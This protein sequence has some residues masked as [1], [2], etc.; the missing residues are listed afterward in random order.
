MRAPNNVWMGLKWRNG[1]AITVEVL[2][3]PDALFVLISFEDWLACARYHFSLSRTP[4]QLLFLAP[5]AIHDFM[6]NKSILWR[7]FSFVHSPYIN[8]HYLSMVLFIL[9]AHQREQHKKFIFAEWKLIA[10][11]ASPSGVFQRKKF[12]HSWNFNCCVRHDGHKA[13]L[14]GRRHTFVEEG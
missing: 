10:K 9:F 13:T 8:I 11:W 3:A 4:N 14:S 1:T 6:Q 7:A 5:I 2:C 12:N